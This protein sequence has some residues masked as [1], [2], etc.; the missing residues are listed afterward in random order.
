MRLEKMQQKDIPIVAERLSNAFADKFTHDTALSKEMAKKLMKLLW[1]EE[2]KVFGMQPYVLKDGDDIVGAFGVSTR[3]RY[4][5]SVSLIAKILAA[6]RVIGMKEMRLFAEEGLQ[7]SR[8]PDRDELYIDFIAVKETR[9]NQG[10]G[11]RL[12]EEI[13]RIKESRS[14]IKKISLYVLKD[15]EPARH[16]YA[17]YGFKEEPAH[18]LPNYFYMVK[19]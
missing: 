3:Q 10:I 5:L 2:Y 6:V 14:D 7:T 1:L 9:R 15:N 12:M 13:E 4:R 19:A 16:L 8:K 11:H 18:V 17:K